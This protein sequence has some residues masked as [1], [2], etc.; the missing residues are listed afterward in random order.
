MSIETYEELEEAEQRPFN[1]Q[2]FFRM[3]G[4]LGRYRRETILIGVAIVASAGVPLFEPY[5]LGRVVDDGIVAKDITVVRQLALLL[6]V[7]HLVAWVGNRTRTWLSAVIGQGVL[8]DLRD[9]LF[10]HIQRLSLRFYDKHPVGRIMSRIT[11]DVE[12][13]ARL[14][15]TGLVT[16][17]GRGI[18]LVG[19]LVVMLWMS[20]RLTLVACVTIPLLSFIFYKARTLN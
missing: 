4:Y 15:N 18:N 5:L 6:L 11:S 2:Y 10:T 9:D 16:F 8:Y 12:S 3:L 19:I 13:I 20:W 7:L 17:V 14:L 1:K